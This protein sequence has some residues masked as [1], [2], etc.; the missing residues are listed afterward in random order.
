MKIELNKFDEMTEV[1]FS[2]ELTIL[3]I[4]EIKDKMIE[5]L[6]SEKSI[7]LNHDEVTEVDISYLQLLKSFCYTAEKKDL[8]VVI[9]DNNT[10][11]LRK[12]LNVAGVHNFVLA[13][14]E[15]VYNE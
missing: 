10:E 6:S 4:N 12:V 5:S 11:A 8:E 13:E 7:K 9:L 14:K 15:E 2:G 3:N 1:K